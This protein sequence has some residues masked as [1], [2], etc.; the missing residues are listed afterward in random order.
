MDQAIQNE[1]GTILRHQILGHM[2]RGQRWRRKVIQG[3]VIIADDADV[4]RDPQP[5]PKRGPIYA[6]GHGIA[7]A[8]HAVD[9][10]VALCPDPGKLFGGALLT[11]LE[12]KH[13]IIAERQPFLG[14]S[15]QYPLIEQPA[16]LEFL[17]AAEN[18]VAAV[19]VGKHMLGT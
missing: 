15:I 9:F 17:R 14:I 6:E 2:D 3:T 8:D 18:Q 4:I 19:S 10:A 12:P 1:P 13:I 11:G 5:Q 16:G 7:K